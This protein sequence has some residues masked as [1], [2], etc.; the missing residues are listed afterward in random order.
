MTQL[1]DLVFALYKIIL[2][3]VVCISGF[4]ALGGGGASHSKDHYGTEN[5]D[6]S[7]KQISKSTP[8]SYAS[9]LLA[10]LFAYRGWSVPSAHS[11]SIG[12]N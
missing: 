9:A 4:V 12:W 1:I 6:H 2:L 8:Y 10:V 5:F 7:F 3:T 11:L